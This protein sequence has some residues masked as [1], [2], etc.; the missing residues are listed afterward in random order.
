MRL[1]A[2][3]VRPSLQRMQ[4]LLV[5]AAAAVSHFPALFAGFTW[6][7][8]GDIESGA[9]IAPPAHWLELFTHGYARTGFYRPVTAL[10]LSIDGLVGAPWMFHLTN[11]ALHAAASV[12]LMQAALAL[13]V[14]RRASVFA[15]ILFAVH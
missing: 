5:A 7:D 9:A 3:V 4:T 15:A 11:V 2:P 13:G 6:L 12:L 1:D 10:S 8:H 14:P